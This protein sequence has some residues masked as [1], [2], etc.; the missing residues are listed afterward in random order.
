M[1]K[2][3]RVLHLPVNMAGV[4][5]E[6]VQALRRKGIEARLLTFKLQPFRPY[7]RD[8][9][10]E[11]PPGFWRRH[12]AEL[13]MFARMLPETD[14]FHFYFGLTLLP[15]SLQFPLL[16]L[17]RRKSVFHFLGSDIRGKAPAE[18]AYAQKA[19]ARIV[20]SYDMLRFVP[21]AEVVPPALDLR[22][23]EPVPPSNRERPIVLHAPSS[24]GRKGTEHVIAA[25]EQLPVELELVEGLPNDEARRR[26][27]RADIVVEQLNAGWHGVFALEAMALGK[28]V[29]T[30]LHEDAVRRTEEAVGMR[31]PIVS[32]TKETLAER[33][34]P[35]VESPEERRR[36]GAESRAYVE[37]VHD[38]ERIAD[39]LLELYARL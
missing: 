4:A 8:I 37:R 38:S 28:P 20:G 6:N 31:V 21:D 39:R 10:F 2:P 5:W 33:L 32:A 1:A 9:L 11:R 24:R 15:R 35:L 25:C 18:L 16:R 30:F 22:E 12:A 17:T 23:F 19:D 36:L 13:R 29:V 3:L 27:A 26:Y 7:E 34:R 14:I